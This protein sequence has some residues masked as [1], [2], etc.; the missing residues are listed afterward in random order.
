[1][2]AISS[3]QDED[4]WTWVEIGEP[5]PDGPIRVKNEQ[6]QYIALCYKH[7]KPVFGRAWS[8]SGVVECSFPSSSPKVE[9]TA[10]RDLGGKI[11]ILS[12]DNTKDEKDVYG[13][14]GFTYIWVPWKDVPAG[15][16]RN[17]DF[18]LVSFAC[19]RTC[20]CLGALR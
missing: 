4:A 13:K 19:A 5:F 1:M 12:Y 7:G 20:M 17:T 9:L 2:T 18:Q 16:Y 15:N 14:V 11:Q 6:N 10:K 8:N 3:K